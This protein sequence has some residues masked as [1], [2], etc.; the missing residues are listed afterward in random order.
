MSHFFAYLGRMKLIRRWGLMR[1]TLPENIQEHSLQAGM[2]AHGL[3]VIRNVYFG[4][5][6][7]PDRAM[8][9][10]AFH[11]IS[12]IFTGDLPTPVKYFNSEIK[13]V[14]GEI[15]SMAKQKMAAMLP[16]EMAECYVP[17][18][19]GERY[20]VEIWQLVKAADK[21]CAYLKCMEELKAGNQEFA[22]AAKSL[23]S[24]LEQSNLQEV[25][26]FMEIF[27]P[28]FGLSLDEMK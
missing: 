16:A 13:T 17:V 2:I 14:Y 28:S 19:F 25:Q 26:K 23:L 3:A 4:G 7:N 10:A 6:L 21:I 1:N 22:A 18:L 9:M 27:V 8:T 24:E 5:S 12:E 15:E 20:D 11:E